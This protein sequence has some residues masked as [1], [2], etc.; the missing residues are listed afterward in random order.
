MNA[1]V[2]N[3]RA[4]HIL[5]VLIEHYLR[6]GQPVGSKTLANDSQL[7]LS[8]AT[9]RNIMVDLEDLGY[10]SSLHTSSGRVP[11]AQGLRLFIDSL[12]VVQPLEQAV[13]AHLQQ[14]I[15]P[16]L[17]TKRLLSAASTALSNISKLAGL[18]SVPRK[19]SASFRQI[20]FL[21]LTSN[22][23]LVI[24]VMNQQEVQNFVI[25]PE[26][27]Y[28]VT[29]LQ[30]VSNF[31]NHHYQGKS[32]AAIRKT[33]LNDLQ[34][35]RQSMDKLLSLTMALA[36]HALQQ[37]SEEDPYLLSGEANLLGLVDNTGVDKLRSLFET[38]TQKRDMLQL[39]DQCLQADGVQIFIGEESGY[40]ILDHCSVVTA[41]YSKEGQVIGVLGVIGPTRMR[42]DRVIPM[43]DATA[44]LLSSILNR[45]ETPPYS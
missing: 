11:T 32:L 41:P 25:Q 22:R 44:K 28:S 21:P 29:E 40:Q 9:I 18:V 20:E 36:T 10:V 33:L 4:Q 5:K 17:D 14:L 31:L 15:D 38:F 8:P 7:T 35:D 2:V 6:D 19:E 1:S 26:R 16:N 13:F 39:L 27:S 34:A 3:E 45:W 42:Y 43:V 23:I 30:H 24:L 12:L 37:S